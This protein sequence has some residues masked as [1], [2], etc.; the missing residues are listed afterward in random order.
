MG[1]Q[2]SAAWAQ[3][4]DMLLSLQDL[5]NPSI[6]AVQAAGLARHLATM[7][8]VELNSYQFT[9]KANRDIQA[10]HPG[11]LPPEKGV[12][13]LDTISGTGLGYPYYEVSE[14]KWETEGC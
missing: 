9:P 8:G 5:T 3:Q 6:G 13:R 1:T 4:N 2:A 12:H 14:D 10:H 7:N 11:L